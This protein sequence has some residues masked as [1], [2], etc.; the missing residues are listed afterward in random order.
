[1]RAEDAPARRGRA[2]LRVIALSRYTRVRV[3]QVAP[4]SESVRASGYDKQSPPAMLSRVLLPHITAFAPWPIR[5][6]A[7]SVPPLVGL[8]PPRGLREAG[9]DRRSGAVAA[10][11][12]DRSRFR[13]GFVTVSSDSIVV[14]RRPHRRAAP[15][16]A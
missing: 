8:R 13:H 9:A 16:Q 12:T 15:A 2:L 5:S 4:E 6:E 11:I 10:R 14:S 3:V 7:M 1:M